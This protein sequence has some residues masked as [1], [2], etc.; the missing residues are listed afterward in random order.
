[1][2]N[3]LNFSVRNGNSTYML[4]GSQITKTPIGGLKLVR[5]PIADTPRIQELHLIWIHFLSEFC[6]REIVQ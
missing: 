1:V 6:E 5:A 2:L 4:T 3:A